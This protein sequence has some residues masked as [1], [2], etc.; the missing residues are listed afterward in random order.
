MKYVAAAALLVL[1]LVLGTVG[2][3]ANRG[4]G[5][6]VVRT[7]ARYDVP[8]VTLLDPRGVKVRLREVLAPGRP[9]FLQFVYATCTT[10]SPVLSA[11]F[12]SFQR[13]LAPKGEAVRLVSVTID[14][15]NDAP[16]V[17]RDYLTRYRAGPTW[18]FLTGTRKDVDAVMKAFDA[19]M[20]DKERHYP[21]TFF[22][23]RGEETW[24][25]LQGLV[26]RAELVREWKS[27]TKGSLP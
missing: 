21:V 27:G 15:E 10:T 5:A 9:V 14:P 18:T 20:P 3:L 16:V 17:L 13:E 6:R 8:D 23:G 12:S 4:P 22:R 2:L 1:A 7:V 19:F 25:R 24:V 11:A 26:G